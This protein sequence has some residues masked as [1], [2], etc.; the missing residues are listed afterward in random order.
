M[1][2]NKQT[3]SYETQLRLD[4]NLANSILSRGA[5]KVTVDVVENGNRD[6]SSNTNETVFH[7][8]LTALLNAEITLPT[9]VMSVNF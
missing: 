6:P 9:P 7:F 1:I 8:M 3:F 4:M 5:L 2:F